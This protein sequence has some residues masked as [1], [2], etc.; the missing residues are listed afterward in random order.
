MKPGIFEQE[1]AR[2]A[3]PAKPIFWAE[4]GL[5]AWDASSQNASGTNLAF[6]GRFYDLVYRM[7]M[8][9]GTD[10]VFFWWYPGG[11]R[12][13]EKSDYGIINP[14]GTDR[15]ATKAIREHGGKFLAGPS[16]KPVDTW[17]E[18]DRD[19]YPEGIGGVYDEVK[20]QFWAAIAE[21]KT[22]G[23]RTAGTGTDSSTCPLTAVGNTPCNGNNPPKYLD[24]VFDAVE[25]LAADGQWTRVTKGGPVHAEAGKPVKVRATLTNLGE[26]AWAATPE[27]GGVRLTLNGE[28]AAPLAKAVPRHGTVTVET[29]I[30]AS[31]LK[32]ESKVT[33]GL[34][35]LN[36]ARFG[37]KFDLVFVPR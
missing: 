27:T 14:D 20:A 12:F 16:A 21:G 34:D 6:V 22:P 32:G 18:I 35:A 31:D 9:G 10:G 7:L 17:I 33:L 13:D 11:Y 24:G 8:E 25:V 19:K 5:S 2:W 23:L 15:P 28:P 36:R 4:A 30:P 37:E 1:Y 26:A 3:A 29:E